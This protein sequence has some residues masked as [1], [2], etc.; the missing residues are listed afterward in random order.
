MSEMSLIRQL[1]HEDGPK[2]GDAQGVP[3]ERCPIR[4]IDSIDNRKGLIQ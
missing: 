2:D 1:S 4:S 3:G